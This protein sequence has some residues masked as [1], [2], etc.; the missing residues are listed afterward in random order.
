ML[1]CGENKVSCSLS[2][3]EDEPAYSFQAAEE[4]DETKQQGIIT[5]DVKS[6]DVGDEDGTATADHAQKKKKKKVN[7]SLEL[8]HHFLN[9]P[10]ITRK[11]AKSFQYYYGP[12][13]DDLIMWT[14]LAD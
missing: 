12:A 13:K 10:L 6:E 8:D 7:Y 1:P 2:K 3:D 5:S 9:L 4:D 11:S 14:I